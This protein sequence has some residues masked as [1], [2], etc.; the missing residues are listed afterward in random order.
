MSRNS[1]SQGGLG[2]QDYY[3]S[4][5]YKGLLHIRGIRMDK[6]MQSVLGAL[7][8]NIFVDLHLDENNSEKDYRE[9]AKEKSSEYNSEEDVDEDE[10]T[11]TERVL[12]ELNL[13]FFVDLNI[14]EY[15]SEEDSDYDPNEDEDEEDSS[16]CDTD[17]DEDEEDDEDDDI[18]E[19]EEKELSDGFVDNCELKAFVESKLTTRR[20]KK[21]MEQLK[22]QLEEVKLEN[23]GL[24]RIDLKRKDC[25]KEEKERSNGGEDE[26]L[27]VRRTFGCFHGFPRGFSMLGRMTMEDNS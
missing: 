4:E 11:N 22:R 25:I 19:G 2:Q 3:I 21:K 20:H 6:V 27:K 16:K 1:E 13:N 14:D 7:N 24:K 23:E 10:G 12:E 26:K 5:A 9:D 15:N 8:L 17:E 18:D